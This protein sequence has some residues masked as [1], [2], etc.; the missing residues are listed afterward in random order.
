M[1]APPQPAYRS[2]AESL[3]KALA[4]AP[5]AANEAFVDRIA[6]ALRAQTKRTA[7]AAE[8][9]AWR[10]SLTALAGDLMDAGLH[11]VEVLVEYPMPH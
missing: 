11:Q 2:S 5:S 1:T 3:F 9:R 4:S 8:K 10:N 7:T 6:T